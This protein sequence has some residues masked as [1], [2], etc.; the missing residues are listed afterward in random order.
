MNTDPKFRRYLV[1][2]ESDL[3]ISDSKMTVIRPNGD[4]RFVSYQ[5]YGFT[6]IGEE[7]DAILRV[8]RDDDV[9]FELLK[10]GGGMFVKSR[11]ADEK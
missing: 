8:L 6:F 5:T 3:V 10:R 1:G 4:I 11:R 2:E 9:Y 7:A